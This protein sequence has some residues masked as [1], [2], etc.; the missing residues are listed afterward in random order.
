M[1]KYIILLVVMFVI[2]S[3]KDDITFANENKV[4]IDT[5]LANRKKMIK[6]E[7]DSLCELQKPDMIAL[8]I[9]SIYQERMSL[10]SEK[11]RNFK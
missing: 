5:M 4:Q 10:Y 11:L 8:A 6:A 7:F 3:C 9:D 2:C 1:R